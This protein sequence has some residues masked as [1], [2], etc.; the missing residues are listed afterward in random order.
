MEPRRLPNDR[1]QMPVGFITS[2][3]LAV[4]G[5]TSIGPEHPDYA[6]WLAKAKAVER[7]E[8]LS[9][10]SIRL[11]PKKRNA[12]RALVEIGEGWKTRLRFILRG[13]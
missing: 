12:G 5:Y 13:K 6:K 8:R 2:D 1:V 10:F 11:R 3:G 7:R 9:T 4:D